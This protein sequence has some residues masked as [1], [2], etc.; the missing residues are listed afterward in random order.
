MT[1]HHSEKNDTSTPQISL[2]SNILKAFN[3]LRGR[4]ARGPTCSCQFFTWL[5]HIRE[6]EVDHFEIELLVE[7]KI[8]RLHVSV[9][10]A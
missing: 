8:L 6:A 2:L 7:K 5:V 1:A 10:D 3:E 9:Y 4:V